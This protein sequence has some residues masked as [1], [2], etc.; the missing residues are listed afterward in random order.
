M[1][2]TRSEYRLRSLE[3]LPT[4]PD[5]EHRPPTDTDRAALA[6]LLLDAYRDTIDD[7]G[8]D[9]DDALDAIDHYLAVIDRDHLTIVD[10][11]DATPIA[12]C[13][14][15]SVD[16]IVYIDPIIV[17]TAHQRDGLGGRLTLATLHGLAD[18]GIDEVG[19]TITDGNTPSERLFIRLGFERVGAWE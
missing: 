5:V 10:G 9:L 6:H 15:L 18:G 4:R 2:R 8:E 13:F 1:T 12:A 11:Q 7:E 16:G 17:A 14:V 3:G 19:A